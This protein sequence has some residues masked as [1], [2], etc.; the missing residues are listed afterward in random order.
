MLDTPTDNHRPALK[1][2]IAGFIRDDILKSNPANPN[3]TWEHWLAGNWN[4]D[5]VSYARAVNRLASNCCYAVQPANETSDLWIRLDTLAKLTADGSKVEIEKLR[6]PAWVKNALD[7]PPARKR[8]VVLKL[9]YRWPGGAGHAAALVF[10]LVRKKQIVYDPNSGSNLGYCISM[11]Q[12]RFH[13]GYAIEP[14]ATREK[15]VSL[16]SRLEERLQAHNLD[17]KDSCGILLQV[18]L[19]TSYRFNFW[20]PIMIQDDLFA[21]LRHDGRLSCL[22]TWYDYLTNPHVQIIAKV[23][24]TLPNANSKLCKAF[25]Q[26]SRRLCSRKSCSA[27]ASPWRAMCWQHR[28]IVRNSSSNDRKCI[29][30][31][32]VCA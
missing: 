19:A 10:D 1:T 2:A 8:V 30:A 9:S 29:A 6:L 26:S 22:I 7:N 3:G 17:S 27:D 16:Q 32:A 13:P 5:V 24:A 4:R 23:K 15:K 28:W 25:S 20:N 18:M 21:V 31:Q 14:T 12:H 11:D